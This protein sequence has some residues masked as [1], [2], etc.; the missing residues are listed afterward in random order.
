MRKTFIDGVGEV[1]LAKRRG[2]RHLRLSISPT[3][4]VRVSLP[5]WAPYALALSFLEER[6][7]WIKHHRPAEP[8]LLRTGS[9]LGR[10]KLV[11][12]AGASSAVRTYIKASTI[13]IRTA[14]ESSDP[15]VQAKAIR[16]AERALKKEA[17]QVLPP[18]LAELARAHHFKYKEVKIRRLTSRWGSCST[19]KAIALSYFLVQLPA[20]LIDYVLL[21][22][23][24]HTKLSQ[25]GPRFWAV[26]CQLVPNTPTYRKEIKTWRPR[27]IIDP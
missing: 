24:V 22:E 11:F 15:R 9:R 4:Q 25:H 26:M 8:P 10:Y 21:H 16:A 6:L 13:E 12:A 5:V 20:H 19:S 17:E 23:L 18:R 7:E 14:L 27:L 1:T 2:N 3:G